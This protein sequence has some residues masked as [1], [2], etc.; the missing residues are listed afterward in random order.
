MVVS[1]KKLTYHN[2]T[3]KSTDKFSRPFICTTRVLHMNSHEN[4]SILQAYCKHTKYVRNIFHMNSCKYGSD[5][6]SLTSG[7]SSELSLKQLDRP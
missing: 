4:L 1:I 5:T 6:L 3:Y 2:R 7:F